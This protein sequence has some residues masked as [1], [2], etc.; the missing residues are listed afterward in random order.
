MISWNLKTRSL[1]PIGLDIGHDSIKMIQLTVSDGRVSVLAARKARIDPSTNG[2]QE[3]RRRFA[4]STIKQMLAK[5]GF[6]GRNVVSSLPNDTLK[7]TSLR[8]AEDETGEI[9]RTLSREAAQRFGLDPDKDAVK[10]MLA[11]SVRQGDE[12]KNELILFAAND[13]DIKTHIGML[14]EAGLRPVSIDAVP[15]ALFRNS[16]RLMRRQEDKERTT[17]FVDVGGMFTTVVFGRGGEIRFIKQIPAGAH[18]FD[19]KIAEKLDIGAKDA[20]ILRIKLQTERVTT[21]QG[22]LEASDPD[23]TASNNRTSTG[24]KSEKEDLIDAETRQV[25]VDAVGSVAEELAKE[26]SLCLR[27]HTVT[28]RGKRVERAIL[29]GGGAY[30]PILLDVLRRKLQMEVDVAEP[31]TEFDVMN[32]DIDGD[33]RGLFCDWGVAVG[34]S[35]KG[36]NGSPEGCE[37]RPAR[38]R[39]MEADTTES[40]LEQL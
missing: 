39:L 14:E 19:Q 34:L 3:Q 12:N 21:S 36:C 1:Q 23:S 33:R 31:L 4:V 27:Y 37:P 17:I 26:I 9:E 30:E 6:R 11:G 32:M 29:T 5:G 7:V 28:F 13:Q 8:L 22:E 38:T 2:G 18:K 25:M 15:C 10:Y 20:E 35:L 40:I 24:Q 16:E